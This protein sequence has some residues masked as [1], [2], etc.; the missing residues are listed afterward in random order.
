MIVGLEIGARRTFACALEWPGWCRAGRSEEE[1]IERLLEYS[2]RYGTVAERAGFGLP[3]EIELGAAEVVERVEGDA[4]T[5]FG[6]PGRQ[7]AFDRQAPA[8]GELARAGALL[9]AAY[10]YFDEVVAGAPAVL[11]KGPRG[12]GRDRD[13]VAAHVNGVDAAYGRKLGLPGWKPELATAGE[14]AEHRA[15]AVRVFRDASSGEARMPGGWP[16]RY[17]ARRGI[18]HLLDHAWEIEDR[19]R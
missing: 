8:S 4:T 9:D 2:G 6:A 10:A 11:R 7:Y 15:A 18:W 13:A 14:I 1:A 17:A 16:L 5:D 3:G 19:S 12:G